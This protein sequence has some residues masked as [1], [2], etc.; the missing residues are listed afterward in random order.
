MNV[1][2]IAFRRLFRKGEQTPIR[3]I[4]LVIG[5]AFS[6]LLLSEVLYNYSYDNF[7]PD[8]NR[9]YVVHENYKMDKSSDEL[10]SHSRVSGAIA[11]GLKAEVPGIEAATRLNS[12]GEQVI[13]TQELKN[14][15]ADVSLADE[16]LFEVLPRKM[17]HGNAQEILTSP[18]S[19]MISQEMADLMG[20]DVM[21]KTLELKRYPDKKVTV[22]GIFET[23]PENTNYQYDMLISMVSTDQFFSWDG[24]TNWMG[25]DRYYACVKL[26]PNVTPESLAPAV[27]SMQIK[28]QDIERLEEENNGLVLQY[29]FEPIRKLHANEVKDQ[30]IILTTIAFAVLF[31]SLLNYILLTMGV[32]IKRAKNSPRGLENRSSYRDI[33]R[34][35]EVRSRVQLRE[36]RL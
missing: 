3:I 7:Y 30:M 29:S 13:Y 8:Y 24:T 14:I 5:L 15:K 26:K 35:L 28:H 18:M 32:L 19:C 6:F 2:K 17:L 9:I 10:E 33:F 16:H 34:V 11:P 20:G 23:L 22:K 4:S 25:N 12:I 27:R 21:G 1:I 31:V 36:S